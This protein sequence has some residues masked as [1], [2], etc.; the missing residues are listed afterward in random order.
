MIDVAH[1]P[2][3]TNFSLGPDVSF[4]AEAEVRRAADFAASVENGPIANVSGSGLLS[5]NPEPHFLV[6]Q[7]LAIIGSYR[8]EPVIVSAAPASWKT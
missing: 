6:S 3:A 8:S 1:W 4:R 5:C 2:F 7:I